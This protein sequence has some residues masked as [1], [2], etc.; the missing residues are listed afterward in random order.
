MSQTATETP[1]EATEATTAEVEDNTTETVTETSAE[2]TTDTTETATEA[3][4]EP[5]AAGVEKADP[6]TITKAEA[7]AIRKENA[8]LRES[9]AKMEADKRRAEFI[10][11]A[12]KDFG[13]LGNSV[14]IGEMLMKAE[15][16]FGEAESNTLQTVLK[17]LAAQADTGKLFSQFAKTDAEGD[18]PAERLEKRAKELVEKGEAKT[19]EQA[20]V[21]VM[22]ADAELRKDYNESVRG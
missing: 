21:A 17:A 19:I 4:P 1:A 11:K 12:E 13:S 5:V 6:E 8:D 2:A 7:D 18:T 16:A 14:G 15:D 22:N 10:A 20:K 3:T 9:V